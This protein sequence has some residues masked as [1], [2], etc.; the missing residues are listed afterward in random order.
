MKIVS[1]AVGATCLVGCY[2]TGEGPDPSAA[3]YVPVGLAVSPAGDA[4]YAA[5]SDFDL[6]FNSGT[7]DIACS[8][9][10]RNA[11]ENGWPRIT[12]P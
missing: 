9:L 7:V 1:I 3:L 4:L 12:V 6:Q 10:I 2:S 11:A 8:R 5:N